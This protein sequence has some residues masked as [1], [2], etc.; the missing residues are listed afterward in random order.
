MRTL[1]PKEW[2]HLYESTWR[3]LY[4]HLSKEERGNLVRVCRGRAVFDSREEAHEMMRVLQPR[5]RLKL[6]AYT[7]PLCQGIHIGNRRRLALKSWL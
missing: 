2:D 7:C 3:P 5:G 1:T 6:G 4:A